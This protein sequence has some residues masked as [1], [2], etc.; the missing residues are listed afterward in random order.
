MK[1]SLGS[2]LKM[3]AFFTPFVY[4]L[5]NSD[6]CCGAHTSLSQ[7]LKDNRGVKPRQPRPSN[8]FPNYNTSKS[9]TSS[10][11]ENINGKYLLKHQR[12]QFLFKSYHIIET[13]W[14]YSRYFTILDVFMAE[15]CR[16]SIQVLVVK[17]SGCVFESWL[18]EYDTCVLEQDA[19][20]CFSSARSMNGYGRG[21]YC[22]ELHLVHHCTCLLLT[23]FCKLFCL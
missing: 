12:K 19:F 21:W 5:V 6:V 18:Y 8:I 15:W 2:D 16:A 20:N 23:K 3:R 7:R 4:I 22:I 17:S 11:T 10:F 13:I 14:I 9:K 1:L